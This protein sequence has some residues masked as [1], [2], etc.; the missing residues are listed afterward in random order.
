MTEHPAPKILN[1]Q[2]LPAAVRTGTGTVV[3]ASCDL[4][5]PDAMTVE[6]CAIV[7]TPTRIALWAPACLQRPGQPHK[8]IRFSPALIAEANRLAGEAIAASAP[9]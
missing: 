7:R 8:S 2:M 1:V 5:I 4:V 3:L 9:A 6:G